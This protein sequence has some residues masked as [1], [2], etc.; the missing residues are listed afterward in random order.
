[1]KN[2]LKQKGLSF[3]ALC[4]MIECCEAQERDLIRVDM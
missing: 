1:M 3:R 2:R 4:E